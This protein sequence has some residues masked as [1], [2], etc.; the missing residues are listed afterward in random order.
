MRK[1]HVI[2]K[3]W[4]CHVYG[5]EPIAS[6]VALG[7]FNIPQNNF[8]IGEVVRD[9]YLVEFYTENT[10]KTL[11]LLAYLVPKIQT[12]LS[13]VNEIRIICG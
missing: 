10:K 5:T 8:S 11:K 3:K 1:Y 2:K 9:I 7:L 13:P 12:T 4:L 6:Y